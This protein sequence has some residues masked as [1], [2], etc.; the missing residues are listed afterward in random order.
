M[1]TRPGRISA[2]SFDSLSRRGIATV[3]SGFGASDGF[4]QVRTKT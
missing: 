3:S 4:S 2:F 1:T